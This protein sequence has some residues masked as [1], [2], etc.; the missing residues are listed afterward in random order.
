MCSLNTTHKLY[1]IEI[2][3]CL[4]SQ[5]MMG[6]KEFMEKG[7]SSCS[8]NSHS[9]F[10]EALGQTEQQGLYWSREKALKME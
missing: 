3:H 4:L 7:N 1:F 10:L 6:C 9:S 2:Y 8:H 5:V